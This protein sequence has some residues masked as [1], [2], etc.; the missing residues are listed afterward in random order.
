M[1][2][3]KIQ[4]IQIGPLQYGGRFVDVFNSSPEHEWPEIAASMIKHE[5]L[6]SIEPYD[7]YFRIKEGDI[8]LDVGCHVGVNAAIFST[9]VG[10]T[11]RV[12]AMEPDYRALGAAIANNYRF[13]NIEYFPLAAWNKKGHEVIHLHDKAYGM[14]CMTHKWLEETYPIIVRTV[15]VDDLMNE[16]NIKKVNFIKMDIE[17]AEV[18]AVNGMI[19]TLRKCDGFSIAA[20]HAYKQDD[21]VI[22]TH[23]IILPQLKKLLPDFEIRMWNAN[24]GEII[25]GWRKGNEDRVIQHSAD[26]DS[27]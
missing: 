22:K 2:I 21:E 20:Y 26:T 10:P 5:T 19:Q 27:S 7:K 9:K 24:D 3:S 8:V 13:K 1:N 6:N 25:S 16:L 15:R 11:G 23:E 18:N 12:I 4:S 17:A 14:S